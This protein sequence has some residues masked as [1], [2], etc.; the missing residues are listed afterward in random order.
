MKEWEKITARELKET[1][2]SNMP[3]EEFEI[4][5]INILTGLKRRVEDVG[6]TLNNE[7]E[8]I[9]NNQR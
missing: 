5:V 2:I 6:R 1:E 3:D 9:S 7:V 8:N 4:M